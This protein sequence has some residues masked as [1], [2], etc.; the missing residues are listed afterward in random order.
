MKNFK[1]LQEEARND[2]ERAARIDAGIA[3]LEEVHRLADIRELFGKSQEWMAAAMATAQGNVSRFEKRLE[4]G[5]DV[6]L[7]TL[8]SYAAALGGSIEVSVRFPE[9]SVT[10]GMLEK[11]PLFADRE[12]E[13]PFAEDREPERA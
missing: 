7:S 9:G 1:T 2:P 12:K 3:Q 8:Q 6:N 5:E 11:G 13:P 4:T 10:L